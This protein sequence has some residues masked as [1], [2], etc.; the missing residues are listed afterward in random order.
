MEHED[1][2]FARLLVG[3]VLRRRRHAES[4]DGLLDREK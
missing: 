3:A 1:F 4:G 2:Q